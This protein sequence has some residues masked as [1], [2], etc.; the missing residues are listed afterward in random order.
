MVGLNIGFIV[1]EDHLEEALVR[2]IQHRWSPPWW[3]IAWHCGEVSFVDPC[4]VVEISKPQWSLG[5][6]VRDPVYRPSTLPVD[7]QGR[8]VLQ[9]KGLRDVDRAVAEWSLWIWTCS[10]GTHIHPGTTMQGLIMET[11]FQILMVK[12]KHVPKL[13]EQNI[14]TTMLSSHSVLTW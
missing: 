4:K 9:H 13:Y 8:L 11:S 12:A 7:A 2:S 6:W 3:R 5:R 10:T 1:L 14:I